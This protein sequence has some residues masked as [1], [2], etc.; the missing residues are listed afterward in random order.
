MLRL[1]VDCSRLRSDVG[2][3]LHSLCSDESLALD[4]LASVLSL[5]LFRALAHGEL[6]PGVLVNAIGLHAGFA[7]GLLRLLDELRLLRNQLN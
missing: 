6:R 7:C 3:I 2:F 4:G 5:R 1:E